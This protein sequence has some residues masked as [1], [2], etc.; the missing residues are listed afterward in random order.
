MPGFRISVVFSVL[1]FAFLLTHI[2]GY[3][4]QA[5]VRW[6]ERTPCAPPQHAY[7]VHSPETW[8]CSKFDT[9][10]RTSD[11]G[12]TWQ[13]LP[14]P[15]QP[16]GE[17]LWFW[18]WHP[19]GRAL[20]TYFTEHQNGDSSSATIAHTTND[21][22]QWDMQSFR[23]LDRFPV[24]KYA[25]PTFASLV[26]NS[27]IL[28][29]IDRQI[30]RSTDGGMRFE[31][32]EEPDGA[33]HFATDQSGNG[34]AYPVNGQV[35][36]T[37]DEG[38]TWQLFDMPEST[39]RLEFHPDG[40]II[41]IGSAIHIGSTHLQSWIR[42][43]LPESAEI[44]GGS[45]SVDAV[46]ALD[47]ND[48]WVLARNTHQQFYILMTK[49]GGMHW[50]WELVTE[51]SQSAIRLDST[52]SLVA[53]TGLKLLTIPERRP[54]LLHASDRS[55]LLRKEVLLEWNDP[56]SAGQVGSYTL[57]RAGADSVWT[58]IEP[59]PDSS[60]QFLYH[61]VQEDAS[62]NHRYRLTMH[63]LTGEAYTAISDSL[64]PLRGNY[65]DLIDA[66][67]PGPEDG[68]S[69]VTYEH[70]RVSLNLNSSG[71]Y[72][73]L[74][75]IV[76]VV[77]GR[78]PVEHPSPGITEYPLRKTV[79][80]A[81]GATETSVARVRSYA[82]RA[83]HWSFDDAGFGYSQLSWP[84]RGVEYG[85]NVYGTAR[86][87]LIP[88]EK[89]G[90]TL[91]RDSITLNTMTS[92]PLKGEFWYRFVCKPA[93]GFIH[94]AEGFLPGNHDMLRF[95][96]AVNTVPDVASRSPQSM[97]APAWPNPFTTETM[98]TYELGN[99]RTIRLSVHDMLGREVAV[100]AEG[101]RVAGRHTVVFRA[102]D[103]P[104]GMF[105]ARLQAGGSVETKMLL[106][107]R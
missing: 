41:G 43:P 31:R 75:T 96:S 84:A 107:A 95:I 40:M 105:F 106:R 16:Q 48:V 4:T 5:Q 90:M 6:E 54:F 44:V 71:G 60:V 79:R 21:G 57:E 26:G 39:S 59:Q 78:L 25:S 103:L 35:A 34:F 50:G 66:I 101:W 14:M 30:F 7:R 68:V 74:E 45:L 82:D 10:W 15:S 24:H 2:G 53:A 81:N 94:S 102:Q 72:D 92:V 18:D 85:N 64:T 97:L 17:H 67:L 83:R 86:V 87:Q 61:V 46:A 11:A 23:I 93:T 36:R 19:D 80:H 27:A 88:V 13:R 32:C 8:I 70:R 99:A 38:A 12:V 63:T 91:D 56:G 37:T 1:F 33:L 62:D 73:T 69:S 58:S 98:L 49:D 76:T 9:L 47:T 65:V 51:Q 22:A 28:F 3:S 20:L 100:L 77:Y 42:I 104:S 89:S 52:R 29:C 55:S